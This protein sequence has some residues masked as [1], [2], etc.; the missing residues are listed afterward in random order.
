MCDATMLRIGFTEPD[1]GKLGSVYVHH[2]ITGE[3]FTH[4]ILKIA[5]RNRIPH[6]ARRDA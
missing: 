6:D 3:G 4:R 2:G 1:A 5:C